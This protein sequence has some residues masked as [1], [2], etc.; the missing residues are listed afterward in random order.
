MND[1][2]CLRVS[3]NKLKSRF[4]IAVVYVDNMNLIGT[5]KDVQKPTD[6]LKN[7]V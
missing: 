7:R 5:L 1:L 2:I 3:I 6:Y 4:A